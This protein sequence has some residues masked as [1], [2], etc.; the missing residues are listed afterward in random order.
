MRV[1]NRRLQ[2][3]TLGQGA[4]AP[5]CAITHRQGR[6]LKNIF[7]SGSYTMC[8]SASQAKTLFDGK[9]PGKPIGCGSFACAWGVNPQQVVK[10]TRDREDVDG[11]VASAGMDHVIR[12]DKIVRLPGAGV[13]RATKQKIDLYAIVA[14]RINPLTKAQQKAVKSPLERAR[15]A[16]LKHTAA[17]Q[18]AP[19]AFKV[20]DEWKAKL[21]KYTCQ[22]SPTKKWCPEFVSSFADVFAELFRRGVVWQDAHSGNI[23][24]DNQGKWKALDLGFSGTKKKANI[25]ALNGPGR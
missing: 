10:I 5:S 11:L 20:D 15:M 13:D 2:V 23:G 1:K 4:A 18:G 12:V 16:V 19:E 6:K 9:H 24:L 14:E 22:R 3:R 17:H 21:K 7:N 25:P 8:L